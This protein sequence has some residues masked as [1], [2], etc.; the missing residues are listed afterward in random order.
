MNSEVLMRNFVE[1]SVELTEL[2]IEANYVAARIAETRGDFGRVPDGEAVQTQTVN[3]SGK[4]SFLLLRTFVT[5]RV[6]GVNPE[7]SEAGAG[8][9]ST[10]S[11]ARALRRERSEP[12]KPYCRE[13]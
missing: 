5:G 8:S 4:I 6:R 7:R 1:P 11:P 12:R 2:L 9:P 3:E 13:R 10:S